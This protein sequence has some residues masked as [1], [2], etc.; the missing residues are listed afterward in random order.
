MI[1]NLPF[2]LQNRLIVITLEDKC[3]CEKEKI[4]HLLN[5]GVK[6]VHIRKPNWEEWQIEELIQSIDE[7]YYSKLV[8]HSSF[9]LTAKYGL[10]GIH[11]G[12]NRTNIPKGYAGSISYSCHSI[13]E[14]KECK[15]YDYCTL[16]PIF[17][18]IS[19]VGYKSNFSYDELRIAA[20]EGVI[21]EHTYALGGITF[22]NFREVIELGFGG[23]CMLGAIWK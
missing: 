18:S 16:S 23:V 6:S 4:E 11:L 2:E 15:A 22:E 14:L 7:R 17:D 8:L 3:E 5:I 1:E 20:G 9:D 12:K 13:D 10:Q 21:D 19:K